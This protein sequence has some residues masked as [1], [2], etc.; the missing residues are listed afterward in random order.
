MQHPYPAR[1]GRSLA[2]VLVLL[3]AGL[4][5]PFVSAT[6]GAVPAAGPG[7]RYIA[8]SAC[9]GNS[10]PYWLT[11][12]TWVM[13]ANVTVP[14]GCIL[15][16]QPGVAVLADSDVRLY[17][18]GQ[19]QANGTSTR[20]ISF[21]TNATNRLWGGVQF[22]K[23][24]RG[25]YLQYASLRM[26]DRGVRALGNPLFWGPTLS[27]LDI[28]HAIV[29]VDFQGS[30]A[31]LSWSRINYTTMAIRAE[32]GGFGG[33]PIIVVNTITTVL[34]D[35]AIAIYAANLV[36]PTIQ[37]NTIRWVNGTNGADG[38][39][40]VTAG[41]DGGVAV[42]ILVDGGNA[43][44]VAGNTVR[45]IL[46]GR[47][48]NGGTPAPGNG[49]RGGRGGDA[50][51]IVIAN[52]KNSRAQTNDISN[53]FG[54]HGGNGGAASGIFLTAGPGGAGGSA[55]AMEAINST[56]SGWWFYN[57]AIGIYGGSAGDAGAVGTLGIGGAGGAAYGH[58]FLQN[59]AG[60]ASNNLA[61]TLRGG[62][63]GNGS[64]G[65]LGGDVGGLWM[66]GIGASAILGSNTIGSLTGGQGG[67]GNSPVA[68]GGNA[69]AILAIGDSGFS[70]LTTMRNNQVTGIT[71]GIG[72]VGGRGGS[73]GGTAAG[74]G[75]VYVQLVSSGNT[76]QT[77][78]GGQGG[79]TAP[80]FANGQGGSATGIAA[81]FV[82]SAASS[83]DRIQAI[84]EGLPGSGGATTPPP[85]ESVG[86]YVLGDAALPSVAS[87]TNDTF[88]SVS[89]HDLFLDNYTRTTSLNTTF[90]PAKLLIMPAATLTVQNHLAVKALWSNNVT[91][92][93]GVRVVVKDN[94]GEI[95]NRTSF[96]GNPK[97]IVVT[98][99]VY[100][101]SSLP[102]WNTTQVSVSYLTYT[103][104]N[105]PR[106]VNMTAGQT[107]YFTMTDTTPPTSS[108]NAL[109]A[110]TNVL[111]FAVHYSYS[112]GTGVGVA[113]ITLW[114]RLDGGAWQAYATQNATGLN[115]GQF[116][117]T[118]S[119]DGTY[120]FVTIAVDRAGNAEPFP[121][122]NDTWTIVD[123]TRP[124]SH[125][126]ALPTYETSLSFTV[127][128]EPDPGV[129]DI[130]T[131]QIQYNSGSGW[132][133]WLGDTSL[134]SG[135]FSASGQGVY[136]FRSTAFDRAGNSE[137]PPATNDTW[138]LVDT[139]APASA[140]QSLPLYETTLVFAVA[141]GPMPGTT[142]V[143]SYQIQVA[144]NG[145]GWTSW[146]V[147][148]AS[149]SANFNGTDGH[150]YA[151]RS[152][153]TD[154]AG[155]VESKGST[156][157]TWTYVDVTPPGSTVVPLPRYETT[158]SFGLAWRPAA[159]VTDAASYTIYVS[160]DGGSWALVPGLVDTIATSATFT[161][162][163]GHVYAF[164]SLARDYA[165]NAET[166][167]SGND[168]FTTVDVTRPT[169]T[170]D[171]P[172]G[173]GTNLT[174][175]ITLTFSEAMDPVSVQQAFSITPSIN[176]DFAWSADGRTLTFTPARALQAS[177]TYV[178]VVD[179]G[180][181]DLAGNTMSAAKTFGFSTSASVA[182]GGL[183]LG[184]LLP[185][186]ALVLAA[187]VGGILFLV[188]RRRGASEASAAAG[189]KPAPPPAAAAKAQAAIDDVFLLYGRDG[190][191][192]KHET[193]R[194][195]PD[196]DTDILSGM[197]TAVQQFVKDSFRGEEGEELNEMTVGQMH[198]LIG[199]GKYLILA[200]T[201]T[202][203]DIE[204]M[205]SQIKKAVQDME[206]HHWDQL[207]DWDG[208]MD[209]AKVLGP[210]IR[211]LIRGEYV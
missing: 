152:L 119:G 37:A 22:N 129:T 174:P 15:T 95:Y 135:V 90:A 146:L 167:S 102:L 8:G 155:N 191:L 32:D 137:I 115:T 12:E 148:G 169:V 107:Q 42:G 7:A 131:Y 189:S 67:A 111:T 194:L 14:A 142:D 208:D 151:F 185:V 106:I 65:G 118:A 35:P 40:L 26:V 61:Q 161:G 177:T 207:E 171:A 2:I 157:D 147:A 165:G 114:Y 172:E 120:E 101:G 60:N 48:G 100:L 41:K 103:F 52:A 28:D 25:S 74:I 81:A 140:V 82:T 84:T 156:N 99:R 96:T 211:K 160:D 186:L 187:L 124:A 179:T 24:S 20:Y 143:T 76:L 125:V 188:Y 144:D 183:S 128:W 78:T 39:S 83:L 112:D 49:G 154:R 93:S 132:V 6:P 164:R 126:L 30:N 209:V 105:N 62:Y 134:T 3:A 116:S 80:S 184:D 203:G 117:F 77:I 159:G 195:R 17:L 23:S 33:Y 16:I 88:A 121:S 192:I 200:A 205:T 201:V 44:I 138:T 206:D 182:G 162:A 91:P 122:G 133:T 50:T 79:S 58:F 181:K 66:A 166:K 153:A 27:R 141:W 204:S 9:S 94:G 149:G 38:G 168:T 199:R 64:V 36:Q 123:T 180:A 75:A 10:T 55:I 170:A 68:T 19:L 11:G 57:D 98:N 87:L 190:V 113:N 92:V 69:T 158:L 72:G 139:L 71:G 56:T 86:F 110:W 53:I 63:G 145:G 202:G 136:A 196:I 108:A 43:P 198:I 150:R 193:R 45:E 70:N 127:S 73:N 1:S 18:D 21:D 175:S 46:G 89:R 104:G 176:G 51:A 34:S 97:W 59:M 130:L 4:T 54:G 29:G 47:G 163:D 197:L 178:V 31:T 173:A 13:Y 109:P 5:A 210:Y 85:N